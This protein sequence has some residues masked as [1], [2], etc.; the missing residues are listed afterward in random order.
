MGQRTADDESVALARPDLRQ[1]STQCLSCPKR[2]LGVTI[3]R[4]ACL[5]EC[6]AAAIARENRRARKQPQMADLGADRRLSQR[7]RVGCRGKA[8][9]LDDGD[10]K[11]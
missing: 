4:P 6:D 1:L 5:C 7:Q 11:A 9:L 3:E 2:L 8:P 10:Q